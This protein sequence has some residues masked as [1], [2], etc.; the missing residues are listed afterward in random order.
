M[1]WREKQYI[2]LENDILG[3]NNMHDEENFSNWSPM[4]NFDTHN[5]NYDK[6]IEICSKL[7]QIMTT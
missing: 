6:N 1:T 3:G 5:Q 2:R 7:S 4:H